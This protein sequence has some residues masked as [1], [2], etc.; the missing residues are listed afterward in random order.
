MK[1]LFGFITQGNMMAMVDDDN[2]I[3]LSQGKLAKCIVGSL[4]EFI[5]K[6]NSFTIIEDSPI[7]LTMAK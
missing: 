3:D 6:G 4:I 5:E 7:A 1:N 2:M